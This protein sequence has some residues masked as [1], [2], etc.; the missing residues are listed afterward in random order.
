MPQPFTSW[1]ANACFTT[2]NGEWSIYRKIGNFR[3]KPFDLRNRTAGS[4]LNITI[5]IG[6][7]RQCNVDTPPNFAMQVGT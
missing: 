2:G 3:R 7:K 5:D 4:I 6:W 1:S